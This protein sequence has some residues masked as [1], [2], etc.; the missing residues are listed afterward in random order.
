MCCSHSP[1][2]WACP[3]RCSS[4]NHVQY[5][6][7]GGGINQ[8]TSIRGSAA[9]DGLEEVP[10]SEGVSSLSTSSWTPGSGAGERVIQEMPNVY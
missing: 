2:R 9:T 5:C 8:S 1:E 3:A 10:S 4:P 7:M 6:T